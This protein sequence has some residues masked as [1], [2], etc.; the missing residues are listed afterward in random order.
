MDIQYRAIAPADHAQIT[1]FIKELYREDPGGEDTSDAKIQRT[2]E[3]L[4]THPDKGACVVFEKDGALAGYALLINFWS[5]ERGGNVL[6]IDEIYVAPP[7]RG[8]GIAT[9]FMQ[10]LMRTRFNDAVVLQLEVTPINIGARKLYERLG[11]KPHYN[12]ILT[13]PLP[14]ERE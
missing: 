7:F 8:Q 3:E 6:I 12:D 13:L 2:F 1:L 5:N 14:A 11:F 4:G 10:H 9:D